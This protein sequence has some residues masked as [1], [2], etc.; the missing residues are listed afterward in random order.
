MYTRTN[1]IITS[2]PILPSTKDTPTDIRTRVSTLE[3]IANIEVPF[4][5]MIFYVE[6]EGKH[7]K[8]KSLKG[9]E[10]PSGFEENMLV[11]Q[12]EEF[13]GSQGPQGEQG[14]AGADG[15]SAYQIAVD[16]G[17][18]GTEE[19]WLTSLKGATGAPG[20]NGREVEFRK[21][22]EGIEW[23]YSTKLKSIV[24]FNSKSS[25][26][27]VNIEDTITK[28]N[29]AN[30]NR[31]KAVYV[32]I[33]TITAHGADAD[34]KILFN[35][36]PSVTAPGG[37]TFPCFGG[38]DPT[39]GPIAIGNNFEIEGNMEFRRV[40]EEMIKLFNMP[41]IVRIPRIDLYVCILN[42]EKEEIGRVMVKYTI[43]DE[44]GKT[45]SLENPWTQV[46][47]I[48]EITG[49]QGPKGEAGEQGPAGQDGAQGIQG[50]QGEQG[51]QG[52]AGKDGTSVRIKGK[53]PNE[54]A[55]E[56]ITGEEV[57]D[58]YIL[59]DTGELCVFTGTDTYTN[60]GRIVGPQGPAGQDGAQGPKGEKGDAFTYDD[61]SPEQ[62]EALK[63][64]QGE[65]GP[66][67]QD[68][69]DGVGVQSVAINEDKHLIVTL[70]NG[71][72]VDA[73]LL[74]SSGGGGELDP[75]IAEELAETKQRLLDLT[76]GV[77]YEWIYE[78]KQ[79]GISA[80]IDF[81]P[82]NAPK[83][84]EEYHAATEAGGTEEENWWNMLVSEDVYRLYI[85]RIITEPKGLN[86]YDTLVPH[87][88]NTS[89][90]LGSGVS[91]WNPI[92]SVTEFTFDGNDNNGFLLDA[93]PT[94]QV[95]F[96]LMKVR[97]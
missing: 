61:F 97:K 81:N 89:Q 42:A 33:K 87:E 31:Q 4:V 76:Y 37:V 26:T 8:V 60:V 64:P 85:L 62:L 55:I 39:K 51:I 20:I 86:R 66:A 91:S 74:P 57:G 40:T 13:G 12:Y 21:T 17:F 41:N 78:Y 95:I 58:G 11:D 32:Q 3:D 30:F 14:P 72:Q 19:D 71:K 46:V 59:E 24:D 63:G 82:T 23:R 84:F 16:G 73:G 7:Y 49:P 83:F 50:P 96:A 56:S 48:S 5:G 93:T 28:L 52:P 18:E 68:G 67:G 43:N 88:G 92:K 1:A 25:T 53:V 77:D 10:I 29:L 44:Y 79:P 94:S 70:T 34:G 22:E 2:G 90:T 15:K 80:T 75:A 36:N 65:Q 38:F 27:P 6:S 9:K 54:A 35:V 45:R 47:S 69:T